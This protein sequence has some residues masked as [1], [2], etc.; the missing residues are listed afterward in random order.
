MNFSVLPPEISSARMYLGAGSG[1]MLAAASAWDG[2]VPRV[3]SENSMSCRAA[4]CPR[5]IGHNQRRVERGLRSL[6]VGSAQ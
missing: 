5:P 2:V 4:I 1:P 6:P 3:G